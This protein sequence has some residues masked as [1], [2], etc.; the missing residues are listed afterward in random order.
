[1]REE[2]LARVPTW[3]A[4]LSVSMVVVLVGEG[5]LGEDGLRKHGVLRRNLATLEA[6]MAQAEQENQRLEAESKA[7]KDN[8]RYQEW[9]IRQ[10]LGWVRPGERVLHV[11]TWQDSREPKRSAR[12]AR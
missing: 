9:V 5:F 4:L 6:R 11:D 12:G 1:M 10:E 2:V 8:P 3:L 7:L